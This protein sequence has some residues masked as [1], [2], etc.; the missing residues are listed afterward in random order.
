MSQHDSQRHDANHVA[1]PVEEVS[2]DQ[3]VID[4]DAALLVC[5]QAPHKSSTPVFPDANRRDCG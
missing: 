4:E 3:S 2:R 5:P 1:N